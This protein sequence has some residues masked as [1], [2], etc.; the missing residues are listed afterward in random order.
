[1][2]TFGTAAQTADDVAEVVLAT[3]TEEN[4]PFRRQ[5]SPIAAQFVG[6]KLADRDGAAVQA[7]TGGWLD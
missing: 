6:A 7:L 4:P 5:T 2:A 3:L 1:M